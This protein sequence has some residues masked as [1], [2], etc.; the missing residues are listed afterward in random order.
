MPGKAP[1]FRAETGRKAPG[2]RGFRAETQPGRLR[3]Y[4]LLELPAWLL[5][6]V[7]VAYAIASGGGGTGA[8]LQASLLVG[9]L[10][11][12]AGGR[13]ASFRWAS[14]LFGL[15]VG[16]MASFNLLLGVAA[17]TVIAALLLPVTAYL[18]VVLVML[19]RAGS[20]R[21]RLTAASG[22]LLGAAVELLLV[23]AVRHA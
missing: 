23:A 7:S 11:W 4:L 15:A 9:G 19:E 2:K 10:A 22:A 13:M 8:F 18:S 20:T 12:L 14:L 17:G 16:A 3:R 5:V 6:G 21:D 1:R